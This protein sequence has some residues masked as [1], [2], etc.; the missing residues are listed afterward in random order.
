MF[1]GLAKLQVLIELR[2]KLTKPFQLVDDKITNLNK[3]MGKFKKGALDAFSSVK[4]SV[5]G[6]SGALEALTNPYVALTAAVIGLGV[7]S[8]QAAA[9]F[10]RQFQQVNLLNL[11]KPVAEI[12]RLREQVLDLSY[13]GG[14]DATKTAQGFFDVQSLTGKYGKEV[15]DIVSKI[16]EFSMVFG[17]DQNETINSTVKAMKIYG[18][19]VEN[20]DSILASN[21]KTVQTAKTTYEE[22]FRVQSEYMGSAAAKGQTLDTANKVFSAFTIASKNVEVAANKTKTAFEGL[23]QQSTIDAFK[24]IGVNLYDANGSLMSVDKILE[25]IIPKLQAMSQQQFD[26]FVNTVGGPDGFKDLLLQARTAGDKLLEGFRGF[27]EKEFAYEKAVELA[28]NSEWYQMQQAQNRINALLIDVGGN[29]LPVM[30]ALLKPINKALFQLK[31]IGEMFSW[32]ADK[33]SPIFTTLG[34]LFGGLVDV[35]GS[36]IEMIDSK[37]GGWGKKAVDWV[38]DL[39]GGKAADAA[40]QTGVDPSKMWR[41]KFDEVMDNMIRVQST[42]HNLNRL[43]DGTVNPKTHDSVLSGTFNEAFAL[44]YEPLLRRVVTEQGAVLEKL[45]AKKPFLLQKYLDVRERFFPSGSKSPDAD[46]DF[47]FDETKFRDVVSGGTKTTNLTVNIQKLIEGGVNIYST[48][49]T[50]GADEASKIVQE[51]LLRAVR[52]FEQSQ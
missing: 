8:V 36:A 15:E 1:T 30:V 17:S 51:G 22:L 45:Y 13:A 18:I 40:T 10:E 41:N 21:F 31:A 3:S 32:L 2:D 34:D 29:I 14:F 6:L 52:N 11:D 4:N 39:F 35:L 27:D 12:N 48:T 37:L 20:I 24:K 44:N 33:L 43:K 9:K 16:S 5:P 19:E 42:T 23:T 26:L 7:A 47:N 49:L 50:H 46:T 25:T 28:V 38:K